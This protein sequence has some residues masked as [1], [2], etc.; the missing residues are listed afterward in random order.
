MSD[1][2]LRMAIRNY[3]K[4]TSQQQ[5]ALKESVPM[6]HRTR[7]VILL[8]VFSLTACT[9]ITLDDASMRGAISDGVSWQ[10][11]RADMTALSSD[12]ME[13][14]ASGSAGYGRAAA[15][16]AERFD[17]LG[18]EAV[19]DRSEGHFQPVD[20]IESRLDS[21]ALS[22]DADNGPLQL[23]FPDD[24][25]THGGFGPPSES[26]TAPLAF[27][28]YGISA[29]EFGHDDY[30]QVDVRGRIVIVLSGAP[31]QFGTSER[32]FY[33][34]LEGKQTLALALGATGLLVV[35]TPVDRERQPWPQVVS[36][37]RR[38]DLRWRDVDGSAHSGF[39]AL[40]T[41]TLSPRGAEGV[42]A[43]NA[44]DLD[45]LFEDYFSGRMHSFGLRAT[46]TFSRRSIQT[47]RSSP[48]VIGVLPGSD[49]RLRQEIVLVSA[50][51]D[52][53][54]IETGGTGDVIFNGAYDNAAGVAVM[55]EVARLLAHSRGRVRRTVMFAAFTAEESGLRGS[56]YLAH[57]P[58][59]SIDAFVA[60]LNID[61]PYLGYPFRDVEGYGAAHSTLEDAL[62]VA[63]RENGL[64]V[65][66]DPRPELVRL[67]RSDQYSFVRQGIPGMNLKPG[68]QSAD[69]SIDGAAALRDFLTH[70]YHQPSDEVSLPFSQDAAETF[71]RT[72][73]T[74]A[75]LIANDEDRPQWRANDFFG[76]RFGN[77][78]RSS[79]PPQSPSLEPR[80]Q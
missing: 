14:R 42:F 13:G 79:D 80:G 45:N 23:S 1:V 52:H 51:L 24:F 77:N 55:L 6:K 76:T 63:A 40:P 61:M 59:A 56:D 38:S 5:R 65:S 50:H 33:S 46:A 36:G 15:F 74:L 75:L 47:V 25:V 26:V 57:H 64:S 44:I 68:S 27:V 43:T 30:T 62:I 29:P 28:G 70:H 69:P 37:S 53:L 66:P 19:G 20:F 34:S 35:H 3:V 67:I 8:F 10:R 12:A 39:A 9:S 58:P 11:V 16:V 78:E 54:G 4:P 72:A 32:A 7:N 21:T 48:N 60:N 41:A 22:I 71:T 2:H 49:R 73:A 18:L 17:A 31:A